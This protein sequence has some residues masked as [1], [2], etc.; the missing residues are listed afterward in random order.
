M[1]S[2]KSFN[3]VVI[4]VDFSAHA[5]HTDN[6][7][8]KESLQTSLGKIM[9]WKT[10]F[11]SLVFTDLSISNGTAE[12][13]KAITALSYNASTGVVTV[14][15]GTFP[16]TTYSFSEGTT[17]GKFLVTPSVGNP[18]SVSIHGLG[19]MAYENK[20][21]YVAASLIGANNGIAQLGSDGKVPTSQLPSY[22][23]DIVD[24][25]YDSTTGKMYSD[26][27]KTIEI[28]PESGKIYVDV[29]NNT[30]YR[31][32]G[33]AYVQIKGDLTLG[34]TETTAYRGDYGNTAYLH[35]QVTSG[36]PHNVK[37]SDVGLGNV[38][39]KSVSEIKTE[40]L[41]K[42]NVNALYTTEGGL[43][44]F[45]NKATASA[46]GILTKEDF[47][48]IDYTNVAYATCSTA[49]GTATKVITTVDNDQWEL[50][51]GAII[52]IKF[53]A[54]NSASNPK[55]DV[56]GT[57]AK[58][59]WYNTTLITSSNKDYAGT[60][61]RPMWFIYDGTQYVFLGWSYDNAGN[62]TYDRTVMGA[63]PKAGTKGVFQ[64]SIIA[65]DTSDTYQALTNTGG[66]G[67]TKTFNTTT[68]FR[69]APVI[70]YYTGAAKTSGQALATSAYYTE[71]T[72]IDLRYSSN[73]TS[74]AG[75]TANMPIYI[76]CTVS[77]DGYWSP[78]G[79]SQTFTSGKYYIF[80][81]IMSSVY[82][83]SMTPHHPIY[84]YDGTNL[85]PTGGMTTA[86]KTKLAGIEDN[87]NNYVHPTHASKANGFY[88]ITVDSLG[89]VSGTAGV[90][91]TDITG[92]L[93]YTP[94][95]ASDK[96]VKN[97]T[98]GTNGHITVSYTDGS[99]SSNVTVYAHPTGNGYQHIPTNGSTGNFLKYSGT[100]G[101][102]KWE[103]L[104]SSEVTGALGFTPVNS[105][106]FVDFVGATAS[107]DGV[108]GLVPAPAKATQTDHFLKADGSWSSEPVIEGDTLT[109][110]VGFAGT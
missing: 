38:E 75:F 21:N 10:D 7:V 110:N 29:P 70:A 16:N 36:N 30:T 34:I 12:T 105:A 4:N 44:T 60:A 1:P 9:K 3:N 88:K 85:L 61:N 101:T 57:G 108:H 71:C 82:Q 52:C 90:A 20:T 66:T 95:K 106:N 86:E 18:Y 37:K 32:S 46:D 96:Y 103:S 102:A 24:A 14:T 64:Y 72:G 100:A 94:M 23:D 17:N 47:K 65:L 8:P 55:F 49:A 74:S 2:S 68:P 51:T 93:G 63:A 107:A 6:L 15:K 50:K 53:T 109:L 87:A 45:S 92:A 59:V 39:N 42:A 97:V 41:T 19:N 58:S 48:K 5:N 79:L 22:V 31:W 104:T 54:T 43:V 26:S 56:N 28:S 91:S 62:D 67:T 98:A 25:Y 80:L 69:N 40:I 89:H 84:Y 33:T 73:I 83:M 76:Q 35:S 78:E 27:A 81:G 77:D 13:G 11:K 99:S